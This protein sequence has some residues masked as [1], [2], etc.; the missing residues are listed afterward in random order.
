MNDPRVEPWESAKMTARLQAATN[1]G[2]PILLRVNY[3]G[4]HGSVTID[5]FEEDVADAMSFFLWQFGDP[6]FQPKP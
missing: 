5:Q 1:S 4:G 2:K 6:N 3:T